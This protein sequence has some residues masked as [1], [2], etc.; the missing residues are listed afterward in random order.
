MAAASLPQYLV[1]GLQGT[2]QLNPG[3]KMPYNRPV[4]YTDAEGSTVHLT[5]SEE[6]TRFFFKYTGCGSQQHYKHCTP[7]ALQATADLLCPFCMCGSYEWAAAH[8]S[9]IVGNELAF[10]SLLL[11]R[12][13]SSSWCHQVRHDWWSACI[14][15]Y[16]WQQGVYVQVDGHCHWHGM[17]SVSHAEVLARDLRCN[18]SAF[19][20]GAAMV[21]AH[22]DDLQQPDIV[23]AAI[24]TAIA[25][26]AVVF[27]AG[28]QSIGWDHVILL[29]QQLQYCCCCHT[30]AWG[31]IVFTPAEWLTW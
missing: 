13:G 31:N 16:N 18:S 2:Q 4:T 15:F 7:H 1:Q 19:W 11:L 9:S 20:A 29:Q 10:M 6:R 3:L 30:D 14:D 12:G 8:K 23:L 22:E 21:R 5:A 28:Y 27:T 26:N 25:E 24:E 17:H